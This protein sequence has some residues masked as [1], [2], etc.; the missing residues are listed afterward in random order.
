MKIKLRVLMGC[1]ALISMTLH[2]CKKELPIFVNKDNGYKIPDTYTAFE[3]VSYTGQTQRLNQLLEIKNY[4]KT[5]YVSGNTIN[6]EKLLAMFTND[7]EKA[8]WAGLYE[9]SKQIKNKTFEP[10]LESKH[11]SYIIIVLCS[12]LLSHRLPASMYVL[13]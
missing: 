2:S 3:N 10:L 12:M 5:V 4:L 7:S 6:I 1:I 8:G 9:D 13:S 11:W